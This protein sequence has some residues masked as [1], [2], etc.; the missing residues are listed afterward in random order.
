MAAARLDFI[1]KRGATFSYVLRWGTDP[2]VY[3]PIIAVANLA[4]LRFTV[5]AHGVLNGSYVAISDVLGMI[6]I[7]AK[8]VP[9]RLSDYVKAT[10]VDANTIELN[11]V[12]ATSLSPYIS[13]GNIQYKTPV[14]LT[15]FTARMDFRQRPDL[16]LPSLLS[17]NTT[18]GGVVLDT[19]LRTITLVITA[20][21]TTPLV[22]NAAGYDLE[23]VSPT[24]VVTTLLTGFGTTVTESTV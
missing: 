14:D 24:G 17:L 3:K 6:E 21:A 2:I 7:N 19:T 4:P 11:G 16:T 15:G 1:I 13:G 22:L 8:G 18:N 20:A 12:N 23:L 10:V 5:A 9:P